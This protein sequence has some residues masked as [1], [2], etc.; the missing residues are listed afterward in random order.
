VKF[1]TFRNLGVGGA[2]AGLVALGAGG[3]WWMQQPP[4]ATEVAS[5]SKVAKVP[6]VTKAADN[7]HVPKPATETKDE[8]EASPPSSLPELDQAIL[9]SLKRPL[10]GGKLKDAVKVGGA[11]VNLYADSGNTANRAKVDLDRDEKWDQK[12]TIK[13]G[14]I[15]RKVAPNDDENYTRVEVFQDGKWN[16]KE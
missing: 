8:P 9:R 6:E 16:V 10:P 7:P 1:N 15:E 13:G 3:Y 14:S 11:K 4:S 2:L 5:V 12:W